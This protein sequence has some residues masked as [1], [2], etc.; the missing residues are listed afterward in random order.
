VRALEWVGHTARQVS[1]RKG[2][3]SCYGVAA[4]R[5]TRMLINII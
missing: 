5:F 2:I 1:G 3:R 4:H